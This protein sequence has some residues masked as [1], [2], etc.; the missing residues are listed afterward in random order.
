MSQKELHHPFVAAPRTNVCCRLR[1]EDIYVAFI[2]V[3][4]ITFY[5]ISPE[6]APLSFLKLS[7]KKPDNT[8]K[9]DLTL[10]FPPT[11]GRGPT[12]HKVQGQISSPGPP[13]PLS[14]MHAD[15]HFYKGC[16]FA[17]RGVL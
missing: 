15:K 14:H 11:F 13:L 10:F 12:R 4:Y 17:A 6:P 8:K 9:Y 16:T 1:L 5:W 2:I 3:R 7:W